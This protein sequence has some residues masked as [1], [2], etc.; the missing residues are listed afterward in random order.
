MMRLPMSAAGAGLL[1]S[2]LL[3]AGASRETV[4]LVTYRARE[5]QSLILDGEWHEFA[6]RIPGDGRDA[7]AQLLIAGI[8]DHEFAIPGQIVADITA[9]ISPTTDRD[10]AIEVRIEALTIA[11]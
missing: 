2:L 1:R 6:L 9:I 4:H 5:W 3:R 7:V 8:E 11:E 10:A